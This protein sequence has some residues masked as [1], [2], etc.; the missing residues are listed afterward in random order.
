[1]VQYNAE[2]VNVQ[3]IAWVDDHL[4]IADV[5]D[6]R[7]ER[8]SVRVFVIPYPVPN[9]EKGDN[10]STYEF[11]YPD[12]PKDAQGIL[13]DENRQIRIVTRAEQGAIYQA[14]P[15]PQQTGPNELTRVAEAPAW[16]TDATVLPSGRLALRTYV[17]V[18]LLEPETYAPVA[19][20]A[21][22]YQPRGQAVAIS[23]ADNALVLGSGGTESQVLRVP[24]PESLA[25]VP[26]AAASPP[27]SPEPTAEPNAQEDSAVPDVNRRGTLFALGLAVLLA[28]AAG[29]V[30]F[31]RDSGDTQAADD[32]VARRGVPDGAE[33]AEAME[34]E[35]REESGE[36]AEDPRPGPV[37]R[38]APPDRELW[39]WEQGLY[40]QGSAQQPPQ[41]KS[42]RPWQDDEPTV[43]RPP[44]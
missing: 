33:G 24:I 11:T 21:L 29:A 19:R 7:T 4:Y 10:F 42:K 14:P 3:G 18:E 5:G 2:P 6:G 26:A 17:S 8:G 32:W 16:V 13:V 27:P 36:T 34:D 43:I 15:E 38:P 25:S 1:T 20:A 31:F 35:D 23:M 22:P 44:Q 41:P 30:V 12:G 39:P 28:V 9:Q 40:D 37:T